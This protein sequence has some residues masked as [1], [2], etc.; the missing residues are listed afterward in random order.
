M[1]TKSAT[2]SIDPANAIECDV[3]NFWK[4]INCDE[5]PTSCDSGDTIVFEGELLSGGTL[6]DYSLPLSGTTPAGLTF[7]CD[8]YTTI[9]QQQVTELKNDYYSLTANYSES[10]NAS[11]SDLL[12]KGGSLSVFEIEENNCGSSNLIIGDNNQLDNLFGVITENEDGTISFWETYL[13]DTT[14]PYTGGVNEEIFSG[15]TAQTFNQTTSFDSEC[16]QTLN[17]LITANG[18]NGLGVNKEYVWNNSLSAC[19][20]MEINNCEGDCEY[21][22]VKNL[23]Q[24]I[25]GG[26]CYTATTQ[27]NVVVTGTSTGY[28]AGYCVAP[29]SL[30]PAEDG[31]ELIETTGATLNVTNVTAYTGS[32]QVGYSVNGT[33]WYSLDLNTADLPYN[34][35]GSSTQLLNNSGVPVP[36]EANVNSVNSP[37]NTLWVSQSS[38]LNGRL[39]NCSIWGTL[40]APNPNPPIGSWIGFSYCIQI[41]DP[42]TYTL[43]IGADNRSRFYL[44]GDL[45]FTSTG[46]S[47]NDNSDLSVWKVFEID[48]PSGEHVIA[49]EGRNDGDEAGF[50]AEIYSATTN[51]LTGMTTTVELLSLIHI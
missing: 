2:F 42:G 1:N 28:T 25:P 44:N 45:L 46:L 33:R 50:G 16:C 39:N 35:Q 22:G 18:I 9:L 32:K 29:L 49:M 38:T 11:Y 37:L 21:S 30:T 47:G 4:N 17:N 43:G 14:T 13:Y 12:N 19:T 48:L 51:Q 31:C 27:F 36:V 6:V 5:C 15:I 20:W 7:S 10:I 3:Y 23:Q 34:L 26:E 40:G 8:T 41:N 24:T